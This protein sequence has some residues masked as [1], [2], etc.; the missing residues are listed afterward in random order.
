MSEKF[1]TAGGYSV[2]LTRDCE[3]ALVVL[4]QAFGSL[5]DTVRLVGGLMPRYLTPA[6]PPEC[7]HPAPGYRCHPPSGCS[8]ALGRPGAG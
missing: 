5:K 1:K 6:R 3:T 7:G 4:L 2:N 8:A